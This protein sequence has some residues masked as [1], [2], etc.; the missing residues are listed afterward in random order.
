[1]SDID[2]F[3]GIMGAEEKLAMVGVNR[4]LEVVYVS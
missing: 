4:G 2:S 3:G 1:M